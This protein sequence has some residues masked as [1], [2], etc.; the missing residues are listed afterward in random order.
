MKHWREC[1]GTAPPRRPAHF[2]VLTSKFHANSPRVRELKRARAF[3]RYHAWRN[4][5]SNDVRDGVCDLEFSTQESRV[6]KYCTQTWYRCRQCGSVRYPGYLKRQAC[7][8]R[9]S[10]LTLDRVMAGI[11]GKRTAAK[12]LK[13]ERAR[14]RAKPRNREQAKKRWAEYT[15]RADVKAASKLRNDAWY[16]QHR[17]AYLK[18]RRKQKKAK[19]AAATA[20]GSSC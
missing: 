1:Q 5:V 13:A 3:E 14:G 12:L 18:H 15:L 11:H 2:N 4:S 20:A 17:D 9:P 6:H 10:H 8:A 19:N 7:P 16:K